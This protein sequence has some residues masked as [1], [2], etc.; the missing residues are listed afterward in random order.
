LP[1]LEQWIERK[2]ESDQR[3]YS[4]RTPLSYAALRG[5][6]V[7]MKLLLNTGKVDVDSKD[8]NG[9][10]PL[11]WA[12]LRGHEVAMKLLLD[13]GKV[14]VD[15]KDD[16]GRTPLLWAVRNGQEAAMKLLLDIG[17]VDV[18]SKDS[19]GRTPLS[20]AAASGLRDI[21]A[22]IERV[23]CSG[24]LRGVR[25]RGTRRLCIEDCFDFDFSS[26]KVHVVVA[27]DVE[28]CMWRLLSEFAQSKN[29]NI[30]VFG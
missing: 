21:R 27:A 14:D 15:S 29:R 4:G 10:T 26:S 22:M 18:D 1:L 30:A 19:Y 8:N 3:D 20:Y 9:R 2:Y 23:L 28:Q 16:Y 24:L 5:H 11:S 7:A 13:T 12:A 6:E 25:S 17:K